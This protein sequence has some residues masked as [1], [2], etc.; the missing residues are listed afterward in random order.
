M[1]ETQPKG[2]EPTI[3]QA[4]TETIAIRPL[5]RSERAHPSIRP[6]GF[7]EGA[8]CA[9]VEAQRKATAIVSAVRIIATRSYH[10]VIAVWTAKEAESPRL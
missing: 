9:A 10:F 8:F 5:V 7:A 6:N 4:H 1:N 3:W 2:F